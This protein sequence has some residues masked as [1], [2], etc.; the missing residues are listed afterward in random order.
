[1]TTRHEDL[2][3]Y[4]LMLAFDGMTP[5]ARTLEW[6][7][8]RR[9]GGFSLFRPYNYTSPGQ[10]RELTVALQRAAR[11]AGQAPL[12]FATDQ[13][14]GQLAAMGEGTTQFAG[15][16]AL[17]ATRDP[18]LARRVGRAIGLELAAMGVNI[19]Y[20]PVL[21]L[22]TNPRNPSLGIRA[23]GDEPGNAARLGAAWVQG[24]QSAGVAAT[25]KHFPGKGE[26]AVDSHYK[27]PVI[28]HDRQRL[29]AV[30]LPPFKAGIE[31]G[32]KLLM[33]GHFAIPALTGTSAYP[34]TV[35]RRVMTD[36]ARGELGFQGVIITDALDMGAITQGVGQII[37]VIAAVRAGVDLMLIMLDADTQE[38]LYNGLNLAYTRELLDADQVQASVKR[39][40]NLKEW[41]AAKPQPDIAVVGCAEHRALEREL[42]RRSITL[43]KDEAGLLPLRL[44]DGA[45]VAAV[46][47]APKDL[48]PADTSSTITPHLG[49][50]IRACHPNVDEFV[51]SHHPT[52]Q[53]IAALRE[54]LAGY[55]LLVL[56]TINASMQPEQPAMVNELLTL[57][58]PTVTVAMRTPYDLATF[59]ASRTHLCTYSIQ[60]ASLD[61]LAAA[62]FG[63]FSPTGQLPVSVSG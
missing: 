11:E 51:T 18:E 22:N 59:P 31:A 21:D 62:L 63:E 6:I 25:L 17:G 15:N 49:A 34:A 20:G 2:I 41:A 53:E 9:V 45:R 44:A 40:M 38:R 1:M 12:L 8:N 46:M 61:A 35:A 16:M 33:T 3:G 55:D 58:I 50:A 24:L 29:E 13:E 32:A 60:P 37:D 36:F 56:G 28:A 42:A 48:T 54:R 47:P 23:F 30:E 19:N 4:K 43:V 57:D 7:A 5:P 52:S 39:I 27:M 10:V 14:G 26:A